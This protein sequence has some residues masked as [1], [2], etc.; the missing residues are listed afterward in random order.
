MAAE[1]AKKKAELSRNHHAAAA[2]HEEA[3]HHH[4]QAAFYLATGEADL[5]KQHSI[6][7]T[8]HS[9]AADEISQGNVDKFDDYDLDVSFETLAEPA[10]MEPMI[11]SII[12]C[13]PGCEKTGSMQS[14]CC[15]AHTEGCSLIG[16]SK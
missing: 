9:Q 11:R 5:A 14:F 12:L 3:A 10:Q 15:T 2:Q 6:A 16:C 1:D 4:R 7:A 8:E 13:T